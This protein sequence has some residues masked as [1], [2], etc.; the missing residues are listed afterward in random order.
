MRTLMLEEMGRI[1]SSFRLRAPT[2]ERTVACP[3][4]LAVASFIEARIWRARARGADGGRGGG[5]AAVDAGL[6]QGD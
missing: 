1:D 6:L 3:V 2:L 4:V 5:A